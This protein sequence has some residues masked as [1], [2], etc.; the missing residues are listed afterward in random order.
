MPY[1]LVV[2]S[3]GARAQ[4]VG[5]RI[6][7]SILDVHGVVFAKAASAVAFTV[8]NVCAGALPLLCCC[9]T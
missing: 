2:E 9:R 5:V 4:R 7:C 8:R 1:R 3:D 6:R